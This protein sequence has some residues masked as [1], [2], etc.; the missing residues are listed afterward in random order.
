MCTE[1]IV[2]GEGVGVSKTQVNMGLGGE[3][4]DS[5]NLV[6]LEAVHDFRRVSDIAM[7]EA[8]VPLVIECPRIVQRGA[9][10]ELIERD[11]VVGIRICHSQVSNQPAGTV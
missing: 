5:I 10:V 2:I 3:V 11:N 1:N 4:E 9:V 8:E 6:A 7:V